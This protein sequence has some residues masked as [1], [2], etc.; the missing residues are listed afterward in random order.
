MRY[1]WFCPQFDLPIHNSSLTQEL[2]HLA[3]Y[4]CHTIKDTL[5]SSLVDQALTA[6]QQQQKSQTE[7]TTAEA[8]VTKQVQINEEPGSVRTAP[9]ISDRP[10]GV[11]TSGEGSGK[12]A[13]ER[14]HRRRRHRGPRPVSSPGVYWEDDPHVNLSDP[15]R[16][17]S[18]RLAA[19]GTSP[20]PV[21][22]LQSQTHSNEESHYHRCDGDYSP[23]S[24]RRR[25]TSCRACREHSRNCHSPNAVTDSGPRRK[26][27]GRTKD[28]PVDVS[29]DDNCPGVNMVR[30][31]Y[32]HHHHHNVCDNCLQSLGRESFCRPSS[33]QRQRRPNSPD[34]PGNN[35]LR[36]SPE[37]REVRGVGEGSGFID[38][39]QLRTVAQALKDSA[40]YVDQNIQQQYEKS[41][42]RCFSP[43][44][45][46]SFRHERRHQYRVKSKQKSVAFD[47]CLSVA[48]RDQLEEQDDTAIPSSPE[49]LT[50]LQELAYPTKSRT[51]RDSPATDM[52]VIDLNVNSPCM[53]QPLEREPSPHSSELYTIQDN[54][55]PNKITHLHHHYHHIIH[56]GE[57]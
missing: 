51:G 36:K 12:A 11:K 38:L 21:N 54:N 49:K 52:A 33:R 3:S 26:R 4:I 55:A 25:P 17:Q 28:M 48:Q 23:R 45:S 57:P 31:R 18:Y 46:Q 32:T 15:Q 53:L 13:E 8:P 43:P 24:T 27:V 20:S 40:V 19:H 29:L 7:R 22:E 50:L 47:D 16:S 1:D 42:R 6:Q 37:D 35:D 41:Q 34:F 9:T 10:T 44:K 14:L 2:N 56:H 5:Q 30:R 39:N